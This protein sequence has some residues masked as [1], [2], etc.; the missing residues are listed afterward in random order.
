[1]ETI[2]LTTEEL[3]ALVKRAKAGCLQEG[4]AEIIQAMANAVKLL[5]Q[6]VKDK[7]SSIKKLLAMVFGPKTEKKEKLIKPRTSGTRKKDKPDQKNGHGR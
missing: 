4:D 3:D 5:S 7:A 2:S 1:M 6:A